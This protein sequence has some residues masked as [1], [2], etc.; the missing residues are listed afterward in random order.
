MWNVF[1]TLWW[2]YSSGDILVFGIACVGLTIVKYVSKPLESLLPSLVNVLFMGNW[3]YED[4]FLILLYQR[5]VR[6]DSLPYGLK[7]IIR[8]YI[9]L[10]VRVSFDT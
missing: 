7:S 6:Y 9:D 1:K 8:S 4:L 2:I 10:D 3:E 5:Y